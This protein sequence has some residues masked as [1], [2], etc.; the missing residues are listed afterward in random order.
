MNQDLVRSVWQR[1]NRRCEYCHLPAAAYAGPFHVDHVVAVQHGGHTTLE[2][3]ALACARCNRRKG[4]NI[5]GRDPETG[6]IVELFHPRKDRWG[7]HFQWNVPNL[8][9]ITRVGR[10]TIHVLGINDSIRHDVRTALNN[11]ATFDWD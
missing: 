8:V 9:G 1:A 2:N 5:A 6:D 7:D 3:L 11:E 10:A 4:P